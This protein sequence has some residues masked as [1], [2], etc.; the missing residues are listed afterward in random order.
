VVVTGVSGEFTAPV[1]E[2]TE[3]LRAGLVMNTDEETSGPAPAEFDAVTD[4][5]YSV[6][7]CRPVTLAVVVDEV[8]VTARPALTGVTVMV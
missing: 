8:V 6:P 2:D 5:T 3:V 4:A 1:A 7:G